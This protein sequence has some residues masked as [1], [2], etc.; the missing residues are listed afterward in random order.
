MEVR[1]TENLQEYMKKTG[2]QSIMVEVIQT[3][4]S[5]FDVTEICPRLI[6]EK[7]AE[8]LINK[9]N[10]REVAAT[11]GRVLMPPYRL[12]IEPVVTFRLKSFL[13]IRWIKQ[14]G[15]SL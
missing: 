11:Y 1:L 13:F 8:N 5:D 2:K 4:N 3:Q 15:I 10:Y 9:K 12:E 14:E 7:M 6:P